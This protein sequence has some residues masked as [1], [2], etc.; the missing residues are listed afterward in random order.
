MIPAILFLM[1]LCSPAYAMTWEQYVDA[2][3]KHHQDMEL[4]EKKIEVL[5]RM[6]QLGASN[7][8]VENSS[9]STSG[10]RSYSSSQASTSVDIDKNPKNKFTL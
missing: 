6:Q 5:A 2:E 3:I 8:N 9:G 7:I 1:L 4:E 10:S